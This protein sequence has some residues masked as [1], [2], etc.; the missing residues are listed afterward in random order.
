MTQTRTQRGGISTV[1]A[2][3][4]R[5]T[6][7]EPVRAAPIPDAPRVMLAPCPSPPPASTT[8]L[9]RTTSR[10]LRRAVGLLAGLA[11]SGGAAYRRGPGWKYHA[12]ILLDPRRFMTDRALPG[13][14]VWGAKGDVIA[15]SRPSV[16]PAGPPQ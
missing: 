6:T 8:A 2:A 5:K 14:V 3:S 11:L 12:T 15:L 10:R 16:S 1:V 9:A 7:Q 4:T 13:Q